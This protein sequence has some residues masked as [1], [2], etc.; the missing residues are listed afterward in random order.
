MIAIVALLIPSISYAWPPGGG[1]G[2]GGGSCVTC[3]CVTG[4]GWQDCTCP[5]TSWGGSGC[6]ITHGE[7][8]IDFCQVK[9]GPCK[10]SIGGF[11]P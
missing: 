8:L 9:A 6:I 2:G 5:S 4:P 11:A 10:P 7:G 3:S 1:G